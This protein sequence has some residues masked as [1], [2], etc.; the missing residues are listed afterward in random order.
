MYAI[1]LGMMGSG[2]TTVGRRAAELAGYEFQDTDQLLV[3][4]LGRPI[5]Q[6]FQFYGEEAFRQHETRILAELELGNGVL[7]TGGGIVLRDENWTEMRRLGKTIFLQVPEEL[8]I[9]RLA[10]AKR[11]RPLL[12]R[13]DWEEQLGII[14]AGRLELYKKADVIL[15]ITENDIEVA[16]AKLVSAMGWNLA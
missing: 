7:A 1:L 8:L 3:R 2:K 9:E 5:H 14:L 15:D 10:V 6:I 16:A 4:K 11:R 12:E 13:D